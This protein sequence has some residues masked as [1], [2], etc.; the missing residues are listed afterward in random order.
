MATTSIAAPHCPIN[1][2]EAQTHG[3]EEDS[4]ASKASSHYLRGG[5]HGFL[6]LGYDADVEHGREDEDETGGRCG[7]DDT[8]DAQDVGGK[9]DQHVDEA[10]KDE[11]DGNVTQPVEGLVGEQHV[12]DGPAHWEENNRDGQGD[13]GEDRQ[14]HAQ[15]QG[16]IRVNPAVGVQKLWLHFL[17]K[18]QVA[19]KGSQEVHGVHDQDGD[20]G[21]VL[22][23]LLSG[24]A[25]LS[26]DGQYLRVTYK[27]K[28]QD[29]DGVRSLGVHGEHAW[30]AVGV[31]H[32][33]HQAVVVTVAMGIGGAV[34]VQ[35]SSR[36][37][38]GI[39]LKGAGDL[40]LLIDDCAEEEHH[41]AE[42]EPTGVA[43][44]TELFHQGQRKDDTY[45]DHDNQVV[46]IQVP[47][48]SIRILPQE[49][50]NDQWELRLDN[51]QVAGHSSNVL[52]CYG[53]TSS[54][55]PRCSKGSV[56]QLLISSN[57]HD[58]RGLEQQVDGVRRE[59]CHSS[60]KKQEEE[61]SS[62]GHGVCQSQDSTAHDG[63]SQVEDRHA[64]RGLPLEIGEA[65]SLLPLPIGQ[66]LLTLS[67]N[68]ISF[69]KS[70][71]LNT[72]C[73]LLWQGLHRHTH[74]ISKVVTFPIG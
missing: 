58:A 10:E 47:Q 64:K 53:N 46:T 36:A 59:S 72:I 55:F 27:G 35:V 25:Q 17:V 12:L 51:V 70:D 31:V 61:N 44:V 49:G 68:S 21:H 24:V 20:V 4:Q 6:V 32:L 48:I 63:I 15:D 9:D 23:S 65:C 67:N 45:G 14:S 3:H 8:E 29:G 60:Q 37:V 40:E 19:E 54:H 33:V 52:Q 38:G 5:A 1:D 56:P 71:I 66:K 42:R 57:P 74:I 34:E 22:H 11:G 28:S 2:D 13:S 26:V 50:L 7:T 43:K 73:I 62:I 30:A 69:V 18:C 16:I 39:F 41:A